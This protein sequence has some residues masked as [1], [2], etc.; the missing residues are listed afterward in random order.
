MAQ[1]LD[2][3]E[4]TLETPA[5]RAVLFHWRQTENIEAL[6]RAWMNEHIA[7]EGALPVLNKIFSP[8]G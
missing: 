8:V 3:P 6:E 2:N 4:K 5:G 1:H 7:I